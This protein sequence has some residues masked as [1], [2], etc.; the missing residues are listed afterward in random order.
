VSK[1]AAVRITAALVVAGLL[2]ATA[3]SA[4]LPDGVFTQMPDSSMRAMPERTFVAVSEDT[5]ELICT[6]SWDGRSTEVPDSCPHGPTMGSKVPEG[7]AL[8][9]DPNQIVFDN[10]IYTPPEHKKA[11]PPG[12]EWASWPHWHSGRWEVRHMVAAFSLPALPDNV[13]D[14][15]LFSPYYTSFGNI[16][17]LNDNI[18]VYLNG[19]Y[20]GVKGT[21]LAA[22]NGG[23]GGTAP[24][25][26]ETDGWYE[27]T[28]FG[29][30]PTSAFKTGQ[31]VLDVVMEEHSG[32]G[33]IGRVNLKLLVA[34]P[35]CEPVE[36]WQVRTQGYWRRQCKHNPHEDI[37]A[38]V[39]SAHALADLFDAFDCDSICELMNVDPP[40]NDMCRKARRQFMALLLNIA[41]GKLAV[42]NCLEDGGE[43]GDVIAEVDSLLSNDPDFRAC[44]HAKT[45]ADNINNG[46]GIV[47]CD[48]LW[49]QV[50]PNAVQ[51]T[52]ILVTPNPFARSTVIEYHARVP[53]HVKLYVYDKAGRL[54][55]TLLD[56]E[57]KEG[58]HQVE[59]DGLDESGAEVPQGIYFSRLQVGTSVES[60]KLLLL[61]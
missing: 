10:G 7:L 33:G 32:W 24:F 6:L 57:Q 17:P 36:P 22:K 14:L 3:V 54:V 45:L 58:M 19:I 29:P 46:I 60:G 41:S 38:C 23:H 35:A 56:S 2:L 59:W 9:L 15:F 5:I 47:P 53:G 52:S 49:R 39:D 28:G 31:N 18:Y 27:D 16:L 12:V 13:L 8:T 25:A 21:Y 43:V 51:P 30:I 42:C 44:E 1:E 50:P 40:E 4:D 34:V 11:V 55:R 61:R 48:T 20:V 37:C 26:N